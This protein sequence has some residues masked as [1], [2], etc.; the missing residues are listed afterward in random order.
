M[1]VSTQSTWGL[2][3]RVSSRTYREDSLK[4]EAMLR[5]T[6]VFLKKQG[7]DTVG[8]LPKVHEDRV[9]SGT[10]PGE[11][12]RH[13]RKFS[14]Y[15]GKFIAKPGNATKQQDAVTH[16]GQYYDEADWRNMRFD[17]RGATKLVNRNWAIDLVDKVP[18]IAV[19][20]KRVMCDGS[21]D[22]VTGH[23]IPG[24]QGHPAVYIN[25][26]G[27]VIETCLYCGLRYYNEDYHPIGTP[28]D[29]EEKDH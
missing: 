2:I 27:G 9:M 21:L 5:R 17:A 3:S 19:K 12:N 13:G 10:R 23:P 20:G 25:L 11:D 29:D 14:A 4:L 26:D 8:V 1:G 22:P 16:T 18:P 24:E 7:L 28:A 15:K 6:C